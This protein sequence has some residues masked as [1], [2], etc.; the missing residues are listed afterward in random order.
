M[1]TSELNIRKEAEKIVRHRD[2]LAP[3]N[4]LVGDI[5]ALCARVR[6]ADAMVCDVMARSLDGE[7]STAAYGARNAL[8]QAAASIRS[9]EQINGNK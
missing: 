8:E 5:V 3:D 1:P 6:E 9:Q 4:V 7:A 2:R